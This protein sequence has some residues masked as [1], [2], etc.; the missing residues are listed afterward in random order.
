MFWNSKNERK[1]SETARENQMSKPAGAGFG[2]VRRTG[3]SRSAI[4]A[5]GGDGLFQNSVIKILK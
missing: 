4:K 2:P 5:Y 1:R 3:G